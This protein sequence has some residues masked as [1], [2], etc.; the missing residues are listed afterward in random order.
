M[1]NNN[2]GPKSATL[3]NEQGRGFDQVCFDDLVSAST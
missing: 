3:P 1:A 2:L